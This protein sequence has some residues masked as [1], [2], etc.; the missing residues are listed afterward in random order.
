M[1]AQDDAG[2]KGELSTSGEVTLTGDIAICGANVPAK[3][4]IAIKRGA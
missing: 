1:S 4:K 3:S 2:Y